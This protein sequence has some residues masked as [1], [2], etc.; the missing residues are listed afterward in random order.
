MNKI[1]KS[2]GID[3]DGTPLLAP[4]LRPALPCVE[5]LFPVSFGEG[6][7]ALAVPSCLSAHMITNLSKREP[8]GEE[9]SASHMAGVGQ[10]VCIQ[11]RAGHTWPGAA[12]H[13]QPG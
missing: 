13:P 1:E 8:A 6:I 7:A 10:L 3:L 11:G 5:C 2:T 4:C 9:A 12:P